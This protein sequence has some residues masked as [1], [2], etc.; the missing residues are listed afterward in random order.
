ML[1]NFVR[2]IYLPL[3]LIG[4]NALAL[5]IVGNDLSRAWLFALVGGFIFL[6][7]CLERLVPYDTAFNI[8]QGDTLRDWSHF[9]V[10][11]SMAV[12]GILSVPFTATLLAI[13]SVWPVG[14]ALWQQLL[15]AILIA[16]IGITLAHFASHRFAFLWRLH[17]VH[18]SVKRMYGFNGLMK[19]PLHQLI[20][21][22]AGTTPLLL[23][24]VPQDVLSLFVVAVLL[25]LLLQHSNVAYFTGPL[26]YIL[27]VNVVHR[28]HHIGNAKEGDV[29]FGLF[30]NLTDRMLGTVFFDPNRKIGSA[31]IGIED[32][33][34][35]PKE[36]LKQLVEPFRS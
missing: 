11:E 6:A 36:Y 27:A 33:P 25:Q 1:K 3:F 12:I 30:T 4:G 5:H 9:L 24:G 28:F 20:E 14:W 23:L 8:D 7:F 18:H 26:K 34:D 29:N 16:D 10:N 15:L 17:A 13:P 19:H 31:D 2:L 22:L 35:Y 21:T 32:R